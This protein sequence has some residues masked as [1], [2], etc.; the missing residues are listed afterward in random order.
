MAAPPGPDGAAGGPHSLMESLMPFTV[1]DFRPR[2]RAWAARL[3]GGL[4]VA[5]GRG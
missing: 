1:V 3:R 2:T 4:V 5:K